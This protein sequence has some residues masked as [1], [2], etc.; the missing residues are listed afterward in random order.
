MNTVRVKDAELTEYLRLRGVITIDELADHYGVSQVTA[1]RYVGR[2]ESAGLAIRVPGGAMD[3]SM[4]SGA[5]V[6]QSVRQGL[7]SNRAEK[8]RIARHAVSLVED[9]ETIFIDNGS[10]CYYLAR[11]L[12][13]RKN[14]TV[15]THA[16]DIA[17]TVKSKRGARVICPGGE[18]DEMLNSFTGPFAERHLESFFA[19][20]AFLGAGSVECG[21]GTLETA[22]VETEI[23][24]ILNRNSQFSYVLADSSKFTNQANFASIP[25]DSMNTV[26]TTEAAP[27][28]KLRCLRERGVE[29]LIASS[30]PG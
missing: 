7:E 20:R 22:L 14:L 17:M 25:A 27:T 24:R 12:P 6:G 30:T 19:D 29:V 15:V 9:G 8:E 23:K 11:A 13:E 26:I 2:L 10:S 16:M 18:L 5:N 28:D 4:A 3:S 1:R 21:K